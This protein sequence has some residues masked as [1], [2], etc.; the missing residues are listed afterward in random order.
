MEPTQPLEAELAYNAGAA[1]PFLGQ[2]S[3]DSNLFF[4]GE[5]A[6]PNTLGAADQNYYYHATTL[7][8]LPGI[9]QQGLDPEKGG[10]GGAGAL[11]AAPVDQEAGE[12]FAE[13]DA[14]FVYLADNAETAARYAFQ[15]DD[16]AD[17]FGEPPVIGRGNIQRSAVI[18]R[19]RRD[20][21]NQ[22]LLEEDDD[23]I[24][25]VR[26]TQRL[27]PSNLEVLTEEGWTPLTDR[28][29]RQEIYNNVNETLGLNG[30]Y[31]PLPY[32]ENDIREREDREKI[33]EAE[34]ETGKEAEEEA[35]EEIGENEVREAGPAGQNSEETSLEGLMA[36]EGQ[37]QENMTTPP[38]QGKGK[39]MDKSNGLNV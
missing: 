19:I 10:K 15:Y 30:P 2:P 23:E 25:A 20:N 6:F 16:Q 27:I 34:E 13:R 29:L 17:G 12:Y 31:A 22:G 39:S 1:R 14:G 4:R 24:G 9:L 18:L 26:T 3:Q 8:N 28:A 11:I 21:L 7:G 35:E 33:E 5:A 37:K 36:E 32:D 38:T